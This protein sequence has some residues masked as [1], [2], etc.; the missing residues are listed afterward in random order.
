MKCY[1]CKKN[2]KT[3]PFKCKFC[4]KHFCD[5]HKIPENHSC[6]GLIEF[7][8]KQKKALKKGK[9]LAPI[10]YFYEKGKWKKPRLFKDIRSKHIDFSQIGQRSH[11]LPGSY[12]LT[13]PSYKKEKLK[14]KLKTPLKIAF[15][16]VVLISIYYF[17]TNSNINLNLNSVLPLESLF[18]EKPKYFCES[19]NETCSNFVK[20]LMVDC[21][22]S[23]I[24]QDY[25]SLTLKIDITKLSNNC[26]VVYYVEHSALTGWKGTSMVC[27]IPLKKTSVMIGTSFLALKY[28]EGSLKD[29][30]YET[31]K[32]FLYP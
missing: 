28:C 4:G 10:E 21:K 13:H 16:L 18:K 20:G 29:K 1:L 25:S 26:H 9:I 32:S 31:V 17:F 8:E 30:F 27:E 3:L 7:K 19:G 6:R 15:I 2:I 24:I 5:N 12:Y 14:D 11:S 22:D 23:I